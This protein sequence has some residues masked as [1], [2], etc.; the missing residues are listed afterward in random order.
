MTTGGRF[1]LRCG[2]AIVAAALSFGAAHAADK[3][4]AAVAAQPRGGMALPPAPAFI[5]LAINVKDVERSRKFY[6]EALGFQDGG[7]FKPDSTTG[8]V[9]R[10]GPDTDMKA[11]TV[12]LGAL[13]LLIR[14]FVK[15]KYEGTTGNYPINQLGLGNIAISV[16]DMDASI[17][18]VRKYG[19]T[20]DDETRAL[21]GGVGP[22]MVFGTDPDGIRIELLQF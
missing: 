14:E 15:P 7:M 3:P 11:G 17:A 6:V 5:N 2:A 22:L 4:A 18:L 21:R 19:G 8:K 9:Y 1:M 10:T 12:R 20:I 13:S 16:K